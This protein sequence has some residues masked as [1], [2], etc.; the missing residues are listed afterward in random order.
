MVIK[1]DY[2]KEH[3]IDSKIQLVDSVVLLIESTIEMVNFKNSR[4]EKILNIM[5]KNI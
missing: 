5:S 4:K 2:L 3:K 1:H